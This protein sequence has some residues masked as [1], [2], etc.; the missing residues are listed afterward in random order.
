MSLCLFPLVGVSPVKYREISDGIFEDID[1]KGGP[2]IDPECMLLA[3]ERKGEYYKVHYVDN[4]TSTATNNTLSTWIHGLQVELIK[5]PAFF[6]VND[7]L[8][9]GTAVSVRKEASSNSAAECT[10]T[11]GSVVMV[12]NVQDNWMQISLPAAKIISPSVNGNISPIN[13][14]WMMKQAGASTLLL[15]PVIPI[16]F[17]KSLSLPLDTGLR[18]RANPSPIAEALEP[19]FT[20]EYILGIKCNLYPLWIWISENIWMMSVFEKSGEKPVILLNE[21][22]IP[23]GCKNG[24]NRNNSMQAQNQDQIANQLRLLITSTSVPSGATLRVRATLPLADEDIT[25]KVNEVGLIRD[26]EILCA[27]PLRGELY[28]EK[29]MKIQQSWVFVATGGLFDGQEGFCSLNMKMGLSGKSNIYTTLLIDCNEQSISDKNY[30]SAVPSKQ[31]E[32]ETI[33]QNGSM[34]KYKNDIDDQPI[35]PKPVDYGGY[36]NDID[37]Q[38]IKIGRASC[39][40]RV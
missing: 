32:E 23:I 19:P 7:T 11:P 31:T 10:L 29:N 27:A 3:V 8:P 26:R 21:I 2:I 13:R 28:D 16:C 18:Q 9:D 34:S 5:F 30:D 36:K 4:T 1:S 12:H 35:K 37:D 25:A 39:R 20:G 17:R 15:L 38:P 22:S 40:E 6:V 24:I 33:K 14:F